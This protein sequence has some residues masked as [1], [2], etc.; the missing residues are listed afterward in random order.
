MFPHCEAFFR[1]Y[2]LTGKTS[3]LQFNNNIIRGAALV[4]TPEGGGTTILDEI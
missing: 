2:R 4:R 3:V 1:L